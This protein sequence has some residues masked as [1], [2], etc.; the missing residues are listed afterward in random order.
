[1]TVLD[2]LKAQRAVLDDE[3]KSLESRGLVRHPAQWPGPGCDI[4]RPGDWQYHYS[5]K[6][7]WNGKEWKPV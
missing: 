6:L 4:L 3:I 1:M 2:D 7:V 5:Q